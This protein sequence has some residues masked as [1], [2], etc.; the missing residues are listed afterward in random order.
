MSKSAKHRVY[1]CSWDCQGFECIVDCT[2]WERNYLVN[3]L[4]GKDPGQP[5]VSLFA[6]TMRA[7][8]NP[9]RNPEIWVVNTT[10]DI[11]EKILWKIAE[12]NPQALVDLIRERGKCLYSSKS[13]K[14]VIK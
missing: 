7:K 12:E 10:E 13:P 4:A 14:Q 11:D 6:L 8:M 3:I 1:I 9:H 2:H 5:P